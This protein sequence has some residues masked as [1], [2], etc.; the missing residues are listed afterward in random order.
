MDSNSKRIARNTAFLYVRMVILMLITVFTSRIL[1]DKLGVDDFGIYNVVGGVTVL[2][3]FF[4]SS[5]TNASQRFLSIELGKNDVGQANAV[6]N[7]HLILY[8]LIT[9]GVFLLAETIGLWF[10]YTQLNIPPGRLSAAICVYHF[11]VASFALT[12]LGIVFNSCIIAHE[13]M[14]VYAMVSVFSGAANLGVAYLLS[15]AA[16]DRLILYG[17][18]M[19]LITLVTQ[20][21]YMIYCFRKFVECRL[22][23]IWDRKIMKE[24]SAVVGWNMVGTAV[25]A[26]NDSG[27]NILINIFFGPAVNAARA[28]SYQVSAAVGNFAT[29]F[30]T[31][32][33]PQLIK[34]YAVGDWDYLMKLFYNS[35][36]YS[37]FLLWIICLPVMFSIREL[38]DIWLVEVPRYADIFTVWVLIH[39]L[40]N[41]FN[42]P[43]WTIA[44]AVG[45]LKRYILIGNG[46]L[47]LIFPFSYIAFKYGVSPV[48][49]F[50][51]MVVL[52]FIYVWIT[53]CIISRYI[54]LKWHEYWIKV[55]FP[56]MKTI[57][58]S[59]VIAA[60]LYFVMP[61]N[62]IGTFSYCILTVMITMGCIWLVGVTEDER[63]IIRNFVYNK[64]IRKLQ[65]KSLD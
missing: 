20:G 13:E 38:L 16:V 59:L 37:F 18:L 15:V 3:G 51:I 28:L 25:Y 43:V 4:S 46:V 61:N 40:V 34:S 41:V 33:R 52:R 55:L 54:S 45:R 50:I 64:V 32:V 1:L 22:R 8:G 21:F 62:V 9:I 11:T 17:F 42:N 27:V 23:W 26:L 47:L 65:R 35:T 2:F 29:N 49:V 53:L 63:L 57:G 60:V 14:N 5:L 24:T 7:Q 6:F 12:L 30:Y 44:L 58:I 48:S 36:K 10:V 39:A 19:F 56:T 31:S